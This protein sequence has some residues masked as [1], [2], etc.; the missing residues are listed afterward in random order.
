VTGQILQIPV[1]LI[2]TPNRLR[3]VD[4]ARAEVVAAMMGDVGQL[5]PIEVVSSGER[6]RLIFGLH[7]LHGARINGWATILAR[8]FAPG[9][10]ASEAEQRLR[11]I[12]ENV[13]QRPLSVLDRAVHLAEWKDVHEALH[14]SRKHGRSK[15]G[16]T[17]EELEVAN[18]ARRFSAEAAERVGLSERAIQRAVFLARGIGPEIRERIALT[19]LADHG[20]DLE[21]L[22]AEPAKR[23]AKI[24]DLL[25]ADPPKA[26][27]VGDAIA[28]LD[29]VQVSPTT[30][31]AR[32]SGAFA[33]LPQREQ[34][35]FFD[36]N[37]A[38][39]D[40]WLAERRG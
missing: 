28:A 32:L 27:S 23:Q 22:A 11:E 5:Q 40:A 33:R 2:D 30:Q 10:F 3:V 9:D 15:D 37:A 20:R 12:L 17:L 1:D 6:F 24:V 35:S 14:P 26:A 18:L 31:V 7:R 13:G 25:F 21:L 19:W 4:P 38:L 29:K 16:R 39:I 34:W 8:V 36:A